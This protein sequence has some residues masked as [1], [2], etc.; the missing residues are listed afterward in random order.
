MATKAAAAATEAVAK[1][2]PNFRVG[3]KQVFLPSHVIKMLPPRRIFSPNFATFQVPLR[4]NKLDLRDYL[5]HVYGVEVRTVRSWLTPQI[6]RR[7]YVEVNDDDKSRDIVNF[8]KGQWYRPQPIKRMMVELVKPF[9]FPEPPAVPT[10]E[11]LGTEEDPRKDWD[12]DMHKRLTAQQKVQEED[13]QRMAHQRKF[14][15]REEAEH[16]P[17]FRVGLARQARELVTGE[18]EWRNNVEL[19]ER[20]DSI[21]E[22]EDSSKA[23]SASKR[24]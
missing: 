14:R 4:F 6:P 13:Q 21:V 10:E 1:A 5:Y 19:D 24:S 20:W 17:A 22:A 11:Q 15:M 9:S 7:R 12:Y 23:P 8:G 2:G 3:Q 16:V 18:R